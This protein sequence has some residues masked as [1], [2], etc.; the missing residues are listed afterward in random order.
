MMATKQ[1][2]CH[3]YLL[4]M[5][6]LNKQTSE[7]ISIAELCLILLLDKEKWTDTW[8]T[9]FCIDLEEDAVKVYMSVSTDSCIAISEYHKS[10]KVL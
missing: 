8:L 6:G 9:N 2:K 4:N 1:F 5:I 10:R 7:I 3:L